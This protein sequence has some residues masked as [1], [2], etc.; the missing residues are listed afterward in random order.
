M[1]SETTHID[2]RERAR[3]ELVAEWWSEFNIEYLQDLGRFHAEKSGPTRSVSLG[4]VVLVKQDLASRMSW[5][6]AQVVK[7]IEGKDKSVRKVELH[8]MDA[9][10]KLIKINR[11][12]DNLYPL[13]LEAGQIARE[14]IPQKTG[15]TVSSTGRLLNQGSK[16]ECQIN[17]EQ[18]LTPVTNDSPTEANLMCQDEIP[19]DLTPGAEETCTTAS[20]TRTEVPST[21]DEECPP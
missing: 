14:F 16:G 3:R 8:T 13:E 12:I 1:E 11:A 17:S 4:Q 5:K 21:G 10:N 15:G 7:L 18:D 2:E 9:E 19:T 6:K 20:Q